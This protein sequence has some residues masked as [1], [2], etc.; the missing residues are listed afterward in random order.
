MSKSN[1]TIKDIAKLAGT[2]FATVSRVLS[3]TSYPVSAELRER[4]LRAAREVNYVP[5]LVGRSLKMQTGREVGVIVHSLT[6]PY[7][8]HMLSN[9]EK[10]LAQRGVTMLIASTNRSEEGEAAALQQLLMRQVGALVLLAQ[11]R[12]VTLLRQAAERGVQLIA[13]QER[14][15]DPPC[16]CVLVDS[17]HAGKM[18]AEHLLSLGHTEIGYISAP[19]DR[20]SRRSYY[21][22]FKSALG[23]RF[24][25]EMCA[26][27]ASENESFGEIYEYGMGQELASQLLK[28]NPHM[29]ALVAGNDL[30]AAGAL[31]ALAEAGKRVPEDI[32][33]VGR[34]NIPLSQM[35]SPT[36]TTIA[37]PLSDIAHAVADMLEN[38][39]GETAYVECTCTLVARA[40][41]G[42]A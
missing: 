33:V 13:V 35:V 14:I 28:A 1:A 9:L 27:A 15:D 40:S 26:I 39:S 19:L 4:V 21:K 11:L 23:E 38:G 32:S 34:D 22:G 3:G 31:Q 42:R 25:E 2:S 6:N 20:H 36:L 29:T 41:S 12:D 30:L 24:R 16:S 5:N 18:A 10:L 37:E 7:Y 17:E 8:T